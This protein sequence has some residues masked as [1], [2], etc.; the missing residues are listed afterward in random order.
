MTF[1]EALDEFLVDKVLATEQAT[2]D[3]YEGRL[4]DFRDFCSLKHLEDFGKA[5]LVAYFSGRFTG[6][7]EATVDNH[8]CALTVFANWCYEQ[9]YLEAHP[10]DKFPKRK[11][12][13]RKAEEHITCFSD[14]DVRAIVAEVKRGLYAERN[15]AIIYT[16]LD[17]GV[18]AG[19][20]CQLTLTDINWDANELG[21]DGKTG[22]RTVNFSS[23]TSFR[24][25]QYIKQHRRPGRGEF[26]L[27]V[28]AYYN[29][30]TADTTD[31]LRRIAQ[32]AGVRDKKLGT[33]TYRHTFGVRYIKSGGDIMT[34]KKILGHTTIRM[35]E[36]YA[37]MD[38]RSVKDAH[39]RFSPVNHLF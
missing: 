18:R 26:R 24:L 34:L 20:L 22:L 2:Q 36:V 37:N 1:Q 10:F 11:R 39:S 7:A 3:Y 14:D 31:A 38:R 27:F 17:T 30:F 4:K 25:R 15:L 29:P 5:S 8:R 19:E 28:T 32:R 21:V 13:K 33:H 23:K 6:L 9:G 35:T 16:L 12:E